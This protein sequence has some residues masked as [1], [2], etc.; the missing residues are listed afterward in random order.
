MLQITKHWALQIKLLHWMGLWKVFLQ[1]TY[2]DYLFVYLS[3]YYQR[4]VVF[5]STWQ[6]NLPQTDYSG[7]CLYSSN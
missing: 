3:V 1:S 5:F 6:K 7:Q 2:T 4:K